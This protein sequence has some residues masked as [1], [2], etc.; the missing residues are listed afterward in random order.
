MNP[1]F[2]LA[3]AC[4][5]WPPGESRNAR[6]RAAAALVTDW[7]QFLRV[8]ARHRVAGLVHDGLTAAQPSVP[9]EILTK[10]RFAAVQTA[11]ANSA[12]VAMMARLQSLFDAAAVPVCFL[13][14]P[15]TG[16]LA[17]GR[18]ELKQGR[19]LDLL[20]TPDRLRDAV[21]CLEAAG[22]RPTEVLPGEPD[23][24][25]HW[26]GLHELNFAGPAGS[27]IV[28]LHW[29]LNDNWSSAYRL[30]EN[31]GYRSVELS[32]SLRV[33]TLAD[34]IGFVYL[35]V[36]GARH[37][38]FRLKWLSDVAAL[39]AQMDRASITR[40]AALAK[41]CRAEPSFAQTMLLCDRLFQTPSV[42]PIAAAYRRDRRYRLLER[43]ALTLMTRG[44]AEKELWQIRFG[45]ILPVVICFLLAGDARYLWSEFRLRALS[46]S[47]FR[48]LPLP[49]RWWFLYPL[50][51]LPLFV[52]RR[53]R[54]RGMGFG[55]PPL[56]AR[57]RMKRER[58]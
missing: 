3:V 1:P 55:L 47:D 51:R 21:R 24:L 23:D 7:N 8:V 15:V 26:F 46:P 56:P 37:G 50:L 4:C 27:P 58:S 54:D 5:R 12:A 44:D 41:K 35:C 17:Y 10:L 38:W 42:A 22:Y 25:H 45:I 32:P 2:A 39:L 11:L 34:D 19:D 9:G 14:G 52:R 48:E 16:H 43:M 29:A 49:R 33:R 30:N 13:K 40:C 36:H 6:I 20:V 18:P 57:Y 31:S 53:I 28:Q